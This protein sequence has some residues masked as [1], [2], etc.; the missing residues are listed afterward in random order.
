MAPMPGV[1]VSTE[2]EVGAEVVKGQLLLVLEAMKME[3]R[4]VAPR[5]GSISELHVEVGEQVTN[6]QLLVRLDEDSSSESDGQ[7]EGKSNE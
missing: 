7:G 5:D 4:I 2:V 3:H 1:V 6:G